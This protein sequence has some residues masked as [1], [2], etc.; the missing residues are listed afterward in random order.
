MNLF[1]IGRKSD[2]I[3]TWCAATKVLSEMK[4]CDIETI[5]VALA[6][7]WTRL[8]YGKAVVRGKAV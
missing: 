1:F 8:L 4:L 2:S 6:R 3:H 7:S 5:T